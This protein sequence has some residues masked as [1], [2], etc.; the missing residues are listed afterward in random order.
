MIRPGDDGRF[1]V[2]GYPRH[3][4]ATPVTRSDDDGRFKV[5]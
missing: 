5:D 3:M 1:K 4:W 2:T